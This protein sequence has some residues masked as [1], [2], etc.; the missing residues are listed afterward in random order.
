MMQKRDGD[1]NDS[2]HCTFIAGYDDERKQVHE[3]KG[4]ESFQDLQ[5]QVA[6]QQGKLQHREVLDSAM[7]GYAGCF[8]SLR[9]DLV[10]VK[11][12]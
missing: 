12:S 6:W 7:Q 2:R 5:V 9:D 4:A 3:H 1:I 11:D 10:Q 8:G